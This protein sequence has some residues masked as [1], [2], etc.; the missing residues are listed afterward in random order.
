M[1]PRHKGGTA[2]RQHLLLKLRSLACLH[3]HP[4]PLHTLFCCAS[5]APRESPEL[6]LGAG[7]WDQASRENFPTALPLLLLRKAWQWLNISLSAFT[8]FTIGF[9]VSYS[10]SK[11][12]AINWGI[13]TALGFSGT[14]R[15]LQLH[16]KLNV[17]KYQLHCYIKIGYILPVIKLLIKPVPNNI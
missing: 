2:A 15:Y 6:L 4:C 3:L 11:Q 10:L 16:T 17:S 5:Y 13:A 14:F 7:K 9:Q 1:Q 12:T 8:R